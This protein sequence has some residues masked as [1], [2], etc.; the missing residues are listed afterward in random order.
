[1][2]HFKLTLMCCFCQL[3]S[4][5]L[6]EGERAGWA[7]QLLERS[8]LYL[9]EP[10]NTCMPDVTDSSQC[11]VPCMNCLIGQLVVVVPCL[12]CFQMERFIKLGV[13]QSLRGRVWKCLLNIDCL[14]ET[15]EF[16][17]QVYVKKTLI[18]CYVVVRMKYFL[19]LDF[20]YYLYWRFWE[21]VIFN[22]PSLQPLKS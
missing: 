22:K 17:Y 11:I 13:P 9:Q 2:N 4:A 3:P 10:G 5:E 20:L 14:R 8:Q 7:A 12:S 15:S 1:M 6:S 19:Y 18:L 16:N 21:S